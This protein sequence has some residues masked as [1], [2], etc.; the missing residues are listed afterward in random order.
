MPIQPKQQP[1]YYE[2]GTQ[3]GSHKVY[4]ALMTQ[5]GT[6]APTVIILQNTIG[7]IVW[8]WDDPTK[9]AIGT[10]AG[11]FPQNKVR[12]IIGTDPANAVWNTAQ[13]AT[14]D[15]VRLTSSFDFTTFLPEAD[16]FS[17]TPIK[18]EVYV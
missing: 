3:T 11:A 13:R 16:A 1:P 10:L 9:I 18:I 15:T 12:I 2:P 14:N 6:S 8:T 17:L 4:T 5:S 7:N